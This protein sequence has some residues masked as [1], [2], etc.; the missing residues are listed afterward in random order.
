MYT[1]LDQEDHLIILMS[2]FKEVV[3]TRH[4]SQTWNG[5]GS[6]LLVAGRELMDWVKL[7]G[8]T[9]LAF[10]YTTFVIWGFNLKCSQSDVVDVCLLFETKGI[11]Q[12]WFRGISHETSSVLVFIIPKCISLSAGTWKSCLNQNN[13]LCKQGLDYREYVIICVSMSEYNYKNVCFV[14]HWDFCL[15]CS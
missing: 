9:C 7:A 12:F 10:R 13:N 3:V 5:T 15:Q 6:D 2:Q 4:V 1:V 11:M 8:T 14:F